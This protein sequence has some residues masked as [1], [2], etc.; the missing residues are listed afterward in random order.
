MRVERI[1]VACREDGS[2][3]TNLELSPPSNVPG[4]H[5]GEMAFVSVTPD[6]IDVF[7]LRSTLRSLTNRRPF[8]TA[9]CMPGGRLCVCFFYL[10]YFYSIVVIRISC[11]P[12]DPCSHYLFFIF[13][14]FIIL[15]YI[16]LYY[17][18]LY[19]NIYLLNE[20]EER[21]KTDEKTLVAQVGF[22]PPTFRSCGQDSVHYTTEASPIPD[23]LLVKVV[24]T[25]A[26][27]S[28]ALTRL[29][30]NAKS[31]HQM[32][33]LYRSCHAQHYNRRFP[34]PRTLRRPSSQYTSHSS[35][36]I[37]TL[38]L[39]LLHRPPPPRILSQCAR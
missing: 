13:L 23:V 12:P 19:L 8:C 20:E 10:F 22:E 26:G 24:T 37:S 6:D 9:R 28:F 27:S 1:V 32:S 14:F 29:I 2:D 35:T 3:W 5:L 38:H 11:T 18:I 17:I 16:I 33:P 7:S 25:K 30:N 39:P 36:T 34:K 31:H 4:L 21:E 15:Y